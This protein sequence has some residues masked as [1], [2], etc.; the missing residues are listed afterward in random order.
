MDTYLNEISRR[1]RKSRNSIKSL[2]NKNG[3]KLVNPQCIANCLN[4][5][6][7]C[8]G[9]NMATNIDKEVKP[10]YTKKSHGLFTKT[11]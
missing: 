5:H 11:T 2:H 10:E 1:K 7:S 9:K 3:E 8:V 4:E 6:F